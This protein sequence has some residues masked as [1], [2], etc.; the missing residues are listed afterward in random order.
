LDIPFEGCGMKKKRKRDPENAREYGKRWRAAHPG[1]HQDY[2]KRWRAENL[3]KMRE[4]E[5]RYRERNREAI[6]VARALGISIPAARE[7]LKR[8]AN[9][10]A[11][12]GRLASKLKSERC[13]PA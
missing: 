12:D 6:K 3:D 13:L 2:I 4:K 11:R 1:Y 9:A 5:H 7:I 8:E 10:N